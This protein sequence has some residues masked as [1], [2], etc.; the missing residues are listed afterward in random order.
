MAKF[1]KVMAV[2]LVMLVVVGCSKP[3]E[4]EMQS[5][6]AAIEKAKAAEAE[7][8]VPRAYRTMMDSLNA[9]NAAKTEQD[10]KFVLF[11]SY[12]RSKEMF[13]NTLALANKVAGDA[14]TEKEKV[15]N[16]V[17]NLLGTTKAL[18]DSVENAVNKAPKGKGNKADIELIKN[19]VASARASYDDANNEFNNGKYLVARS[20]IQA[21]AQKGESIMTELQ[22]AIEKAHPAKKAAPAKAAPAKA[23]KKK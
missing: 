18:L 23:A 12:K 8:Y 2:L 11:R 21:V 10:G 9:A 17:T 7:A 22:A 14:A 5:A 1:A 19:D 20:K 15:K 4:Q 3:P 6:N 16:E 13:D